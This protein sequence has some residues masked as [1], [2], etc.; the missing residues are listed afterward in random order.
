MT[1]TISSRINQV[2]E[3]ER[4]SVTAFSKAVN[5]SYTAISMILK[6]SSKP[7]WELLESILET[8]PDVNPGWLMTGDG[9]FLKASVT[10]AAPGSGGDAYLVEHLHTLEE[11][12][13]RLAKQLESK[14]KQIE[15]LQRTVDALISRP[16]TPASNFL[17]P[18]TFTGKVL[19]LM[20]QKRFM[21]LTA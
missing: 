10:P 4:M 2:M 21:P 17:K 11:N 15:G 5:K 1:N 6:G 9:E 19:P 12:F 8:F 18:A 16:A 7:G 13:A 3:K 20:A 14:D